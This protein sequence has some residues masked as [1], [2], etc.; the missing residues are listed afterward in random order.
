MSSAAGA[1]ADSRVVGVLARLGTDIP[2]TNQPPKL[3]ACYPLPR[4]PTAPRIAQ[5]APAVFSNELSSS[6]GPARRPMLKPSS[7]EGRDRLAALTRN[8]V[9]P[10]I[11]RWWFASVGT[12]DPRLLGTSARSSS[13]Q[14]SFS[15]SFGAQP[16]S[17]VP[18]L[19][20][21]PLSYRFRYLP[22]HLSTLSCQ[23]RRAASTPATPTQCVPQNGWFSFALPWPVLTARRQK[24]H[25]LI[26]QVSTDTICAI[27]T[28]SSKTPRVDTPRK[29]ITV[30]CVEK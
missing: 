5:P 20:S 1:I 16:P 10:V 29:I 2:R 24:R 27:T 28:I 14:I 19:F 22:F 6:R 8:T 3:R 4:H 11:G 12:S 23:S 25:H 15:P 18:R 21:T 7:Y 9:V 26:P 13:V 17:S 30:V